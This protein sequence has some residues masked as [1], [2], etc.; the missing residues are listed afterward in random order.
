SHFVSVVWWVTAL[1]IVFVLGGVSFFSHAYEFIGLRY[2]QARAKALLTRFD[3][4][5]TLVGNGT[6]IG[7]PLAPNEQ[8][9]RAVCNW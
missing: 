4:M 2:R 8:V 7:T 9:L 6:V 5:M 3:E 1:I